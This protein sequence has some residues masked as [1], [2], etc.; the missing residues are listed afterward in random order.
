MLRGGF[1]LCE[2]FM[3]SHSQICMGRK[4]ARFPGAFW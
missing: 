3:L 1:S 4:V 2:T